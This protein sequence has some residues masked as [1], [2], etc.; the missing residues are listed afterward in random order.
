[1]PVSSRSAAV[2]AAPHAQRPY[3]NRSLK[4]GVSGPPIPMCSPSMV[5][6]PAAA[7]ILP[8]EQNTRLSSPQALPTGVP[9]F[10]LVRCGKSLRPANITTSST[11]DVTDRHLLILHSFWQLLHV[12]W[13]LGA[14]LVM[15]TVEEFE[16]MNRRHVL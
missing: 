3:S 6:S 9:A 14:D 16:E 5:N 2:S 4:T 12:F 1:S 10:Q 11:L 13:K 15:A 7:R 8:Y